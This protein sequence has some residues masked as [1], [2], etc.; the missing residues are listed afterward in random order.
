MQARADDGRD[1]ARDGVHG[2]QEEDGV[3]I[4][5]ADVL[6]QVGQV[7]GYHAGGWGSKLVVVTFQG[8][9]YLCLERGRGKRGKG[10]K[11]EWGRTCC[12]RTARTS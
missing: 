5:D 12:R 8:L 9:C 11:G 4:G 2:V 7:V 10:E 1:P 3:R 6:E